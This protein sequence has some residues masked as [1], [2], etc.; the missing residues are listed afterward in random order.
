VWCGVWCGVGVGVGVGVGMLVAFGV[1]IV[2]LYG[3]L[4]HFLSTV[5]KCDAYLVHG[6]IIYHSDLFSTGA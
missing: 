3:I 2:M 5:E 1:Y 4:M 6:D